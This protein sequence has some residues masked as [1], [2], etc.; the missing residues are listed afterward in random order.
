MRILLL[1]T[2][3]LFL[4]I[5]TS[6]AEPVDKEMA[7]SYYQNCISKEAAEN[8]TKESQDFLCACTASE[9]MDHMT[10]EDI[11]AMNVQDATGRAAM[12]YM[13]VKVYAPCMEY[14]AKDHY[15]NTCIS[16]KNSALGANPEK[17]C[18]CMADKVAGYLAEKGEQVFA[19]ILT[20]NPNIV[21]PMSALE[22]DPEFQ[23]YVSKQ[24]LGCVL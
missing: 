6:I 21:D 13:I 8:L 15:Y 14:P 2:L 10:T 23:G 17:T 24:I 7:D 12:N 19:G 20:R 5:T 22:A 16:N 18:N 1:T 4:G 3:V 11:E 9:M